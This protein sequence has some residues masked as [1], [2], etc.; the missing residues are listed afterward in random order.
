M[1]SFIE[2]VRNKLFKI[3]NTLILILITFGF[4]VSC[5]PDNPPEAP[6]GSEI[7]LIPAPGDISLCGEGLEPILVRALVTNEEGEP[8]SDVVVSFDLSFASE[9]S[10]LIDTDGNG[11][12]DAR[13]LQMV[14][15][16]ACNPQKCLNTP[17]SQWF[18]QGAFVDS[19][20]DTLTDD[21]GVAEVVIIIPG[22]F[23]QIGGIVID[24]ATLTVFSGSAVVTEEFSVNTECL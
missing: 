7:A 16:G 15:N 12:P 1:P 14:N 17:I 22:I 9:N 19:P 8:L 23:N 11:L 18:G 24:P 2:K 10:L 21:N 20:Y 6:F 4:I 3:A 13:A 5:G